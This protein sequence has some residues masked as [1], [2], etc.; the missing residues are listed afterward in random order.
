MLYFL[1]NLIIDSLESGTSS[2]NDSSTNII[3]D[4]FFPALIISCNFLFEIKF[5]VGLFGL[6]TKTHP[7]FGIIFKNSSKSFSKFIVLKNKILHP[8]S[9]AAASY[10]PNVGAGINTGVFLFKN[11]W[12]KL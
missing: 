12:Q 5:P 4:F 7:F 11:A 1:T 6:Q 10:S 2:I 3:V 8:T 9:L